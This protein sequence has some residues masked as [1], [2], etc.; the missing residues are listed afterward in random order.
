ML[1]DVLTSVLKSN[2]LSILSAFMARLIIPKLMET[3]RYVGAH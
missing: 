2:P 3:Y 1:A